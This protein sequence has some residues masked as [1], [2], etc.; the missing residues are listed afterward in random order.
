VNKP[1][2]EITC[3]QVWREIS[4]FYEGEIPSDLQ[5]RIEE[6]LE[7]CNHCRAVYDGLRNTVTLVTDDRAFE[8]PDDLSQRLYSR[9]AQY[10][11][12]K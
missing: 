12:R 8:L 5:K 9:F 11:G 6:H 4:N 1:H 3:R 10:H 7:D 2:I